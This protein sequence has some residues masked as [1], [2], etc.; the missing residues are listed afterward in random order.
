MLVKDIVPGAEGSRPEGITA[1]G[2]NVFFVAD[3]PQHGW[4]RSP[5]NP[6]GRSD[7]SEHPGAVAL[8][9]GICTQGD[10][11]VQAGPPPDTLHFI[12]PGGPRALGGSCGSPRWGDVAS[13]RRGDP[14]G[15]PGGVA[16]GTIPKEGLEALEDPWLPG[17][18]GSGKTWTREEASGRPQDR[19]SRLDMIPD[20]SCS[21]SARVMLSAPSWP[22]R[23]RPPLLS[24][25]SRPGGGSGA[26]CGRGDHRSRPRGCRRR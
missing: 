20:R 6:N 7:E 5:T 23:G 14:G 1:A 11:Q 13:R 22:A 17:I 16:P 26:R 2:E 18:S 8:G 10:R 24:A 25:C 19:R 12:G 9:G 4:V 3:H 15:A 21:P